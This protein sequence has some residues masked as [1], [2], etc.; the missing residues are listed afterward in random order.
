[1]ALH[2]GS[3]S[4]S[5]TQ[6][7]SSERYQ[8]VMFLSLLSSSWSFIF[9]LCHFVLQS[10]S[11]SLYLK[12]ATSPRSLSNHVLPL[13][14]SCSVNRFTLGYC[15]GVGLPGNRGSMGVCPQRSHTSVASLPY[16]FVAKPHF[17]VAVNLQFTLIV[18]TVAPLQALELLST[19][20]TLVALLPDF[21]VLVLSLPRRI[22]T[23]IFPHCNGSIVLSAT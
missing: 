3:P 18:T 9:A 2:G 20:G 17:T 21:V 10:S 12:A 22:A 19:A 11:S 5:R 15:H 16:H 4:S 1:M 14:H 13:L 6:V 8:S 7:F 23:I